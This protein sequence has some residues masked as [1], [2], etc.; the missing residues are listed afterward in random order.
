MDWNDPVE[1][2]IQLLFDFSG[3]EY[4]QQLTSLL[5]IVYTTRDTEWY[6]FLHGEYHKI[7]PKYKKITFVQKLCILL[8]YGK[9]DS[10]YRIVYIYLLITYYLFII[11]RFLN[12]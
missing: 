6:D 8:A 11:N 2:N 10:I 3:E 5:Q 4:Y 1:S 9:S 7:P 12:S